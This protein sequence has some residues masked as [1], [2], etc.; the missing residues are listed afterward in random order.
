MWNLPSSIN[1]TYETL[2]Q[3]DDQLGDLSIVFHYWELNPGPNKH[4]ENTLY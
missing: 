2:T 1:L 4:K 3:L